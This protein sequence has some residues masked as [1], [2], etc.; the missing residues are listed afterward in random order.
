[1]FESL[2]RQ[3]ADYR[4][5]LMRNIKGIRVSQDLFD[6]LARDAADREV[7]IAAESATR[8]P[9]PAPLITRPFDYGTVITYP[10]APHHWHTTR[11][12]EGLEY[13]VWYGA[14]AIETTVYETLYHWH[15]FI[16]DSYLNLERDVLGERRVF[17][18]RC[19]A[20]LIDLRA[21]AEPRLIDRNDYSFTHQL[22][23]Y[24]WQRAQS[25][26]LAPS[27]R[28]PGT[29]AAVFRPEAL[30]QVR[31]VCFLTYRLRGNT[32]SIERSPGDTW[33]RITIPA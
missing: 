22:G 2:V 4:G 19:E 32:A 27:A 26:L 7:A 5:D 33:L 20:I 10:F 30:S 9:S 23:R 16:Q 14:L 13:G 12:S 11:Y 6:D 15:R 24:L 8:I 29:C 17:Q 1:M 25:G 21:A 3:V 28:G 31:D 18:V